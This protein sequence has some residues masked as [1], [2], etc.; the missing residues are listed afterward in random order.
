[1]T[2]RNCGKRKSWFKS[3]CDRCGARDANYA[4]DV[5]FVLLLGGVA[6]LFLAAVNLGR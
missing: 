2:C 3:E 4:K 5:W 6:L 1:M